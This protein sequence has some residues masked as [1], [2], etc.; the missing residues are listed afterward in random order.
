ML[1][2]CSAAF[3]LTDLERSGEGWAISEPTTTRSL[4]SRAGER[5]F[6]QRV[7]VTADHPRAS[8]LASIAPGTIY[9]ATSPDEQVAWAMATVLP[10]TRVTLCAGYAI[11]LE[12]PLCSPTSPF[13]EMYLGLAN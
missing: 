1:A 7:C 13:S 5:L 6:Y 8:L 11:A 12:S 2:P 3:R 10:K 9:I 4:H